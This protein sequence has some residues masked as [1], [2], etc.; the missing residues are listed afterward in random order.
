MSDCI[1]KDFQEMKEYIQKEK[2]RGRLELPMFV[3]YD[4]PSDYRGK[5][6]VRLWSGYP[7]SKATKKIILLEAGQEVSSEIKEIRNYIRFPRLPK[8]DKSIREVWF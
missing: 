3:V 8:D 2:Q 5:T 4:S 7:L 6:V 1:M